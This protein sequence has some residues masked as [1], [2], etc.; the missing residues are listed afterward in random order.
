MG[1]YEAVSE[2]PDIISPLGVIETPDVGVRLIHDC[3]MP[4]GRVVN[5][6]N[7]NNWHQK[8][9]WVDDAAA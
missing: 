7:T 5:D 4:H 6:Y 8:F 3:S 9:A 1:N 2:P